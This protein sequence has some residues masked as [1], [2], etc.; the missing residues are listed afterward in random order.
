MLNLIAYSRTFGFPSMTIKQ[1][2]YQC[3]NQIETE[4]LNKTCNNC[5][6]NHHDVC[7]SHNIVELFD[8]CIDQIERQYRNYNEVIEK[9]NDS[10][11]IY[12]S[13]LS[14]NIILNRDEKHQLLE[15]FDAWLL[16]VK[17]WSFLESASVDELIQFCINKV[18]QRRKIDNQGTTPLFQQWDDGTLITEGLGLVWVVKPQVLHQVNNRLDRLIKAEQKSVP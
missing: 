18:K 13:Y 9:W 15:K 8:Y 4:F 1:C 7:T 16:L 6:M 10:M 2:V 17:E 3:G 14:E 11:M 5:L 12:D